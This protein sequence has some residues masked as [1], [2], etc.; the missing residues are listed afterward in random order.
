MAGAE[1]DGAVYIYVL[2]GVQA[3]PVEIQLGITDGSKTEVRE[4]ELRENDAVVI[5]LGSA[6]TQI[7]AGL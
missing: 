7:K 1:V 5:G 6:G 4:G 2:R 3:E